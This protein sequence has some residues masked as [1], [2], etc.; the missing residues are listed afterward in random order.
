VIAIII[1]EKKVKP[2]TNKMAVTKDIFKKNPVKIVSENIIAV[3][4]E[5]TT[6]AAKS[7]CDCSTS[8]FLQE[9]TAQKK[10]VANIGELIPMLRNSIFIDSSLEITLF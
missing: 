4:K 1:A 8:L 6:A 10:K 7:I 5:A 3:A 2:M 9:S